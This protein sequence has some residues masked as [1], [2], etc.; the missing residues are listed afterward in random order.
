MSG[1]WLILSVCVRVQMGRE[2]KSRRCWSSS[3]PSLLIDAPPPLYTTPLVFF[4]SPFPFTPSLLSVFSVF[5]ALSPKHVSGRTVWSCHSLQS[6][7]RNPARGH[8]PWYLHSAGA[9]GGP[10]S[11]G[12]RIC[13]GVVLI[14]RGSLPLIGWRSEQI[15]YILTTMASF[16]LFPFLSTQWAEIRKRVSEQ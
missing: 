6:L 7:D 5:P 14:W 12:V 11:A 9:T 8:S 16:I 1:L 4:L 10:A 15:W 2:V 3:L 13:Q